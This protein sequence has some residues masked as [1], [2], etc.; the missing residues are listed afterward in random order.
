MHSPVCEPRAASPISKCA[1][2]EKSTRRLELERS[3]QS[4]C[5]WK[6]DKPYVNDMISIMLSKNRGSQSS[7]PAVGIITNEPNPPRLKQT[8]LPPTPA[9][10]ASVAKQPTPKPPTFPRPSDPRSRMS[11]GIVATSSSQRPP[12][13][14]KV[15]ENPIEPK[16]EEPG[17]QTDLTYRDCLSDK[18]PRGQGQTRC[19]PK[20]KACLAVF[21]MDGCTKANRAERY[22]MCPEFV[23]GAGFVL[24]RRALGGMEIGR[25]VFGVLGLGTARS[26]EGWWGSEE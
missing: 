10:P 5:Q 22:R 4:P 25:F 21:A 14:E 17:N 11:N 3:T 19:H 23:K 15:I 8:N 7:E 16:A 1:C 9:H 13:K 20:A 18:P 26:E 6:R 24:W 12:K 2:I